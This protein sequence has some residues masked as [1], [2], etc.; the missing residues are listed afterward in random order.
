MMMMMMMV[1]VMMMYAACHSHRTRGV[2]VQQI[3]TQF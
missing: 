2:V 3:V 1:V